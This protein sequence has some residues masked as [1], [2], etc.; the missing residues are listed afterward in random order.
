MRLSFALGFLCISSAV[1]LV[2]EDRSFSQTDT[3]T[4][5]VV[6]IG[7]GAS[8]TYAAIRLK[9]LGKTVAL[10]EKTGELGGHTT[11]YTAE[12]GTRVDFG[13][14]NFQNYSV[15][16]DYFARFNIP[17]VQHA[18]GGNGEKYVD[19]TTGQEI[20]EGTLPAPD[21]EP[22]FAQ[23]AKVSL[24][25]R[26][27]ADDWPDSNSHCIS[28][29]IWNTAGTYRSLCPRTSFYHSANS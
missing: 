22:Y 17:L 18:Q 10:V 5:D 13:V 28:I 19:F 25:P 15:V 26:N 27:I 16:R 14:S 20:A 7:G 9:D 12:G 24:P 11:T 2:V 1:G 23:L 6:V 8:G 29:H 21:F 4:R 3:I